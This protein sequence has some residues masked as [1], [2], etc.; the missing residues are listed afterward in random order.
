LE[1]PHLNNRVAVILTRFEGAGVK[2]VDE[3][4]T[5]VIEDK[6]NDIDEIKDIR[7]NSNPGMSSI[8]I[9]LK[10]SVTDSEPVFSKVQ[11]RLSQVLSQLPAGSSAPRFTDQRFGGSFTY[12]FSLSC[13]RESKAPLA[14]MGRYA[15]DLKKI[16]QNLNH[17]EWVKVFGSSKEQIKILIDE[18]KLDSAGLT[19][20]ELS[21]KI[22]SLNVTQSSGVLY[23]DNLEIQMELNSEIKKLDQIKD[24]QIL[25][26]DGLVLKLSDIAKITYSLEDPYSSLAFSEGKEAIVIGARMHHQAQVSAWVKNLKISLEKYQTSLPHGI[27]VTTIFDQSISTNKRLKGLFYNLLLAMFILIFILYFMMGAKSSLVVASSLPLTIG[28]VL[29]SMSVFNIPLHQMSLTGLMI[30]LG[31]LV[32]N[33]I[34]MVDAVSKNLR[35]GNDARLSISKSIQH[36]FIPLLGSTTTTV[37]AFM[38][39]L[40]LKGNIGEFVG[41]LGTTVV[42]SLIFSMLI[43]MT[44]VP[45]IAAYIFTWETKLPFLSKKAFHNERL[46]QLYLSTLSFLIRFKSIGLLLSVMLP[47]L[48]F[49]FLPMVKRQFF[50]SAD[51][52]QISIQLYFAPQTS[53]LENKKITLALSQEIKN[54]LQNP[55]I[56]WFIGNSAPSVYYNMIMKEDFN[57]SFSE[58]IIETKQK[59]LNNQEINQLQ[60]ELSKKFTSV[61]ILVKKFGQG[62]PIASPLAIRIYGDDISDLYQYSLQI[63]K[64]LS[65][66]HGISNSKSSINFTR[67]KV[68]LELDQ[69]LVL[70]R[71][72]DPQNVA[73][74]IRSKMS[75]IS[76]GFLQEGSENLELR[77]KI[78]GSKHL[79]NL[80]ILDKD[81]KLIP[82][83]SI[84]KAKLKVDYD[85]I[86]RKQS[87]RVLIVNAWSYEGIL[88][89]VLLKQF[90]DK[91]SQSDFHLEHG[92][93]LEYGGDSEKSGEAISNLL[94]FLGMIIILTIATLV[95]SFNSFRQAGILL[96]IA[97]LSFGLAFFFLYITAYP[98][99]FM[100]M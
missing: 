43:S 94:T 29:I 79:D 23:Q 19:L 87:Q 99:G 28:C 11:D 54:Q 66:M 12:V 95:L 5:Q 9:E 7:S 55:K 96:S 8:T 4:I 44:I 27:K 84:I 31:L 83:S 78:I 63:K 69:N 81:K 60:I 46:S 30:S 97:G 56:H 17:T 3:L 14:I 58:A 91:L 13:Q 41:T 85:R 57:A 32:D 21:K 37:L 62:P 80:Q 77:L 20:A 98:L 61:K 86:S 10:D 2:K 47:L 52:E 34:V 59:S 50:P 1:D 6:I 68:S 22:Q 70:Q 45:S 51:R 89:S 42:L 92:Y 18:K 33:A 90:K 64:V 49:L 15:K 93:H 36:L 16:V 73:Q 88:P 35:E 53:M 65:T 39:I 100:A 82:I 67:S 76:A 71:G 48:G 40:L 24:L 72:L 75:G 38:P 25:N 74:Q 26:Q